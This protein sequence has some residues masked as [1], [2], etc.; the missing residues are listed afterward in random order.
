MNPEVHD[1]SQL[2]EK[3]GYVF[4]D[5]NLLTISLTHK[6]FTNENPGLARENNERLEF[7]GDAVLSLVIS[8]YLYKKYS[9]LNEGSLSKIRANLVNENSLASVSAKLGLGTYLFLGKGEEGTGGREKLSLLSDALEAVIGGIYLDR[10]IRFA[11]QV[12]IAHFKDLV[13]EVVEQK[14]PFDFKTTF[15]EICQER[16]GVLP[17]YHLTETSGPDHNR[18]FV[19]QLKV[20]SKVFGAG[21]GK[22]KKEAQQQAALQALEKIKKEQNGPA[23]PASRKRRQSVPK[24][25]EI[26]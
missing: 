13:Q 24:N 12:I 15:Q 1:L 17:E 18:L 3:L 19:M 9:E 14:H 26:L 10:G 11:T 4:E 6:S 5:R 23:K 8:H 2:E 16:Y 7:M 20:N 25:K 21:S 22:N